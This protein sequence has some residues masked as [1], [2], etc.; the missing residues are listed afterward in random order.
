MGLPK[1]LIRDGFNM[2]EN[3]GSKMKTSLG[4]KD[5][6]F[7]TPVFIV[8]TYCEDGRA[9]AMN[10][11]WGGIC[12]SNP[13]CIAISVRR[14]RC[15]HVNITYRKAFTISIPSEMYVKEADYFGMM[16][17]NQ[18]DKFKATGLTPVKSEKVD[19]PY[20]E[21]FPMSFQ[22]K[23]IDSLEIGEHTQFIGEIM[24]IKV[25]DEMLNMD[26]TPDFCAIKPLTLDAASFRYYGVGNLIEK[27]FSA[28]K[29]IIDNK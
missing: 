5:I 2:S 16:S 17:G 23:V 22:C 24:D 8:G 15:T 13:P 9:N 1:D 12:S 10:V 21:E 20:I 27:A 28:G 14:Q 25:D 6:M 29:T 19:A 26:G 18:V 7:P 3:G 4:P 11:A